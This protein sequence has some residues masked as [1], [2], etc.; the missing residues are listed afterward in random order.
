MV[1]RVG[2]RPQD[3]PALTTTCRCGS[4]LAGAPSPPLSHRRPHDDLSPW[5]LGLAPGWS[6]L[7]DRCHGDAPDTA[8][9]RP[10]GGSSL[11]LPPPAPSAPLPVAATPSQRC[12]REPEGRSVGAA[13]RSRSRRRRTRAAAPAVTATPSTPPDDDL[14]VGPRSHSRRR[15]PR[16]RGHG[17]HDDLSAWHLGLSPAADA[18]APAA[19]TTPA[20]RLTSQP[21][22]GVPSRFPL[23]GPPCLRRQRL[24]HPQRPPEHR[25]HTSHTPLLDDSALCEEC[26]TRVPHSSRP[27]THPARVLASTHPPPRKVPP[28]QRVLTQASGQTHPPAVSPKCPRVIDSCD[29]PTACLG[30]RAIAP[31]AA[32]QLGAVSQDSLQP[33][34]TAHRR[35]PAHPARPS[36]GD[37]TPISP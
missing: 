32:R 4:S 31:I 13:A 9:R 24:H 34:S 2:C 28:H 19:R 5:H 1:R 20:A 27:A 22:V 29:S 26:G 30:R 7:S 35:R 10:V 37:Y 18:F 21:G 17:P 6:R 14:S 25:D 8:R 23:Q 12:P 16:D 36:T 15:L 33:G 11:S 3:R